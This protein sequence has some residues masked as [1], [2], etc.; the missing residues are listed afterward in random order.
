MFGSTEKLQL[1][2]VERANE[3]LLMLTI[4]HKSPDS[5]TYRIIKGTAE[6][7]SSYAD[8]LLTR[9]RERLREP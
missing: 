2:M 4:L 8:E 9:E 5:V 3:L 7:V 1:R 6:E